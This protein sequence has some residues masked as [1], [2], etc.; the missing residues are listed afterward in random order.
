ML[1]LYLFLEVKIDVHSETLISTLSKVP[2][3]KSCEI[4]CTLGD[5]AAALV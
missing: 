5:N 4:V 2:F 1:T 3:Q